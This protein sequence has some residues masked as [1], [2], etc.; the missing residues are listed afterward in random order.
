MTHEME[1]L[2]EEIRDNPGAITPLVCAGAA[3]AALKEIG[4]LR[5]ALRI[6]ALRAGFSHQ[7]VD[8]IVTA[9]R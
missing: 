9:Q 4:R 3:A 1:L 7:D 5:G 8:A 6:N 2:L